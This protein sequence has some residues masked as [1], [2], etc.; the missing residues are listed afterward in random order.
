MSK[1]NAKLDQLLGLL[2]Q[3]EDLKVRVNDLEKENEKLTESAD[4]TEE[5][6][7]G[8]K[9]TVANACLSLNENMQDVVS[10]QKDIFN[11]SVA[12]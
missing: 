11:L 4:S 5:E 10:L 12:V 8:L 6:I 1:M 9:S 7:A 3:V 2:K